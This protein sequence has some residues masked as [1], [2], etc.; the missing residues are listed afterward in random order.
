M[1]QGQRSRTPSGT[2]IPATMAESENSMENIG[3]AK[4][5]GMPHSMSPPRVSVIVPTRNSDR[6]LREALLSIAGQSY[7]CFEAIIIDEA[8][9]DDR[10]EAIVRELDDPRFRYVRNAERLGLVRS[11]NAGVGLSRGELIARMDADDVSLPNRLEAQVALMDR[12]PEV[13]IVGTAVMLMDEG[14]KD[15]RTMSFP[16]TPEQVRWSSHFRSPVAHPTAML[17]RSLFDQ[18]RG[19]LDD[20]PY[21]EDYDLWA[22][23]ARVTDVTN[24]AEPLLRYRVHGGSVS[25]HQRERQDAASLQVSRRTMSETL[26]REVTATEA[27]D[28]LH[29]EAVASPTRLDASFR[30]L[31][32]LVDAHLSV[33]ELSAS[34]RWAILSDVSERAS[35]LLLTSPA[36]HAGSIPKV[37]LRASHFGLLSSMCLS[38]Q[39]AKRLGMF[40]R[41]VDRCGLA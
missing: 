21:C 41:G 37:F 25:V 7:S 26:G 14:G 12:R 29:P 33:G 6:Y 23:A 17:R 5:Q 10:T 32:E 9:S 3:A 24:L 2:P 16:T 28:L 1:R 20:C 8:D 38:Y 27:S 19:Y 34:E 30:L 40:R 18:L 15:L 35:L 39:F 36:F 22:R 11:L 4:S 13:G 31:Y